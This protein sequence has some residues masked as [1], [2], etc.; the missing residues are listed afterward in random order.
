MYAIYSEPSE[1]KHVVEKHQKIKKTY[2]KIKN[3]V[4][5]CSRMTS[6]FFLYFKNISLFS[7][8]S[9]YNLYVI[10]KERE[11][12]KLHSFICYAFREYHAR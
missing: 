3:Y 8:F 6:D 12:G 4:P 11:E 10:I 5:F 7:R 2:A 9:I 1:T